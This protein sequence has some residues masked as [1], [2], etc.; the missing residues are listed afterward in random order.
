MFLNSVIDQGASSME[1]QKV[2]AKQEKGPS[3]KARAPCYA[4]KSTLRCCAPNLTPPD[5]TC[6][7]S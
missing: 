1:V 6:L 4:K 7:V 2:G 3:T 5:G